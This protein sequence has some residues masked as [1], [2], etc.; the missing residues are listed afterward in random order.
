MRLETMEQGVLANFPVFAEGSLVKGRVIERNPK[1]VL[2]DIGYKSEGVVSLEEFEDPEAVQVGDEVEVLLE[3][4][5]DE[6]G[7]VLLSKQKAA[8]KQNWDKVV[9]IFQDGGTV[10]GKVRGIVKGGLTLNV[11][12]EAFLPSSQIDIIPPRNLRDFD[13]KTLT[14]KIVKLNE[15]RRSVVL[16]R[17]ELVEAERAEKRARFL[18]TAGKGQMVKGTVKNLTDFGAF[19]DLDG[20]DGL[21]HITDM[22]WRRLSHPS[23]L[24]SVGQEVEVMVIEVDREKER[25]S[26]GLKQK[27]EN[28]WEKIAE[29]FPIQSRIKGRV[30]N[31]TAY[32]AFVELEPGIEGLVHV[33]EMSWTKRITRPAELLSVGQEVEVVVLDVNREEQKISLSLR[34]L[35]VNPWERIA[36]QYPVGSTVKGTVRT[37]TAY[38]IFVELQEGIDGF[39]H[40]NDLSWTRKINHPS[41]VYKKGDPVEAKV[42]EIDWP[43]QK[44]LLGIK[45]LAEDPWKSLAARYKV[46]EIVTGKVSKIASFGAFVQLDGEI[47]GL[48]HISQISNDRIAKVKDVLKVGQDVQARIVK[49]EQ[50]ERRIGLSI[51]ALAYSDEQLEKERERMDLSRPGEELGS[52]EDAF[53]RAEEDYRPG[54]SSRR[55]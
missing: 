32:G 38:G 2:I 20:I 44:I 10:E 54:D 7:S 40:V 19:I 55:G 4:L 13:G 3:Q 18:E 21:L 34:A 28:P 8:Q 11:G 14:C 17:R 26:L 35:E 41:E 33:S 37:F 36:E 53:S 1:T 24:L 45:Q 27:S 48:V 12:V 5:E 30:T 52:M 42:L 23:E 25:I 47:D 16:S 39:V 29:K 22:S 6:E 50:E 31:L 9:K 43:N 49:I 15:E 51:K 46:G